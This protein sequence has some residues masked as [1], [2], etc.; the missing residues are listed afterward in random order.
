V[1]AIVSDIPALRETMG[2]AAVYVEPTDLE[3]MADGLARVLADGRL[4]RRLAAAGPARAA[5]FSIGASV[6]AH[7]TV[8][9]RCLGRVA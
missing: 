6:A 5:A 7:A 9:E 3:S 8:Y 1:P 4:R 2:D